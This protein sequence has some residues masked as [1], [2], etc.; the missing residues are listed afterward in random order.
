MSQE[1]INHHFLM[2]III[3][4]GFIHCISIFLLKTMVF[5]NRFHFCLQVMGGV[6]KL[7]SIACPG[8]AVLSLDRL[9][10]RAELS[11]IL[12]FHLSLEGGGRSSYRN[13]V[14]LNRKHL[15]SK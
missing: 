6:T 9:D 8:T 4:L 7:Y 11:R 12:S 5:R 2:H 13:I 1:G 15:G 10:H 14:V 3:L